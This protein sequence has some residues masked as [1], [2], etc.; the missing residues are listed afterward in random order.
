MLQ[1]QIQEEK[2]K[3]TKKQEEK[4]K[5]FTEEQIFP[6]WLK[7]LQDKK[8]NSREDN[9]AIDNPQFCIVGEAHGFDDRY[10]YFEKSGCRFCRDYSH[11]FTR[12]AARHDPIFR[13]T[14]VEHMNKEHSNLSIFWRG[15]K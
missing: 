14:F 15:W 3:E 12:H 11:H 13:S 9:L 1:E 4:E 6:K 2:E 10:F 5:Y 7:K 8:D